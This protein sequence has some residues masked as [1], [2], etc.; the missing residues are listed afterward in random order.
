[1]ATRTCIG[2]GVKKGKNDFI[3]RVKKD[4]QIEIDKTGK[5]KGVEHIYAKV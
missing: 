1:M 4:A 2:C 5:K 3:R